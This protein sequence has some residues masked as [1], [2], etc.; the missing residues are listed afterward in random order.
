MI[1]LYEEGF[2]PVRIA[3]HIGFCIADVRAII[4][5]EN[6]RKDKA[7]RKARAQMPN[8]SCRSDEIDESYLSQRWHFEH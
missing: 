6:D 5:K 3:T 1:K 2:H 4:N 8:Y 7:L